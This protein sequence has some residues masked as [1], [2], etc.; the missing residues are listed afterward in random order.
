VVRAN[1]AHALGEVGDGRACRALT[2]LADDESPARL[3]EDGLLVTKQVREWA[4]E[5]LSRLQAA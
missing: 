1:A 5:A 3:Y 2:E 4:G